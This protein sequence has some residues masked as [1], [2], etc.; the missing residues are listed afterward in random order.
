VYINGTRFNAFANLAHALRQIIRGR[1]R[2]ELQEC[3]QLIWADQMCINQSNTSERS[4]QVN[5]MRN[6][7]E[8]ADVVLACLGEDPSNGQWVEAAKRMNFEPISSSEIRLDDRTLHIGGRVYADFNSEDSQRNWSSIGDILRSPWWRRGWIY[9]EILV[10]QKNFVLCGHGILDWEILSQAIQVVDRVGRLF[11]RQVLV[12]RNEIRPDNTDK[13]IVSGLNSRFA[14]FMIN[15]REYWQKEHEENILK[16]LSHAGDCSVTDL[17]DRVFAFIGLANP[18]YGITPNYNIDAPAVFRL[19]CKRIILYE[20]SLNILS[21]CDHGSR[22]GPRREDIP[23]WVPDWSNHRA[24]PTFIYDPAND[25]PS[26]RASSDYRSAAA[27]HS[28]KDFSESILRVQCLFIDYL[29]TQCSLSLT[30][31][32]DSRQDLSVWERI[33]GIST[34]NKDCGKE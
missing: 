31:D 10:A 23:S 30:S 12:G 19:A 17:R 16:L 3:P 18:G 27:F 28:R 14:A 25:S 11:I 1:E 20:T 26:F 8:C 22:E 34:D 5:F 32:L 24:Y 15:G 29:A 6:I 7:Y 4:H 2:A 33:A 21:Y 13:I 9:Q